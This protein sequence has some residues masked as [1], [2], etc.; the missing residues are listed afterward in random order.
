MLFALQAFLHSTRWRKSLY[1]FK[2]ESCSEDQQNKVHHYYTKTI[3]LWNSVNQ[4]ISIDKIIMLPVPEIKGAFD[5]PYSGIRINR[6]NPSNRW[7]ETLL[8]FRIQGMY[9]KHSAQGSRILGIIRNNDVMPSSHSRVFWN[10][11]QIWWSPVAKKKTRFR[12]LGT[13]FGKRSC[14][15]NAQRQNFTPSLTRTSNYAIFGHF[16]VLFFRQI[17]WPKTHMQ[18]YC[19]TR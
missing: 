18:G 7:I 15:E 11:D 12:T 16:M 4:I 2:L 17:Q 14:K 10:N 5:W 19:S 9:S 8:Q 6:I 3:F 1:I 13:S